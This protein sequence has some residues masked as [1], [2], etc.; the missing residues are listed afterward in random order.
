MV[1]R[2]GPQV[3]YAITCDKDALVAAHLVPERFLL[4]GC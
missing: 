2:D 1:W 4:V 3:F